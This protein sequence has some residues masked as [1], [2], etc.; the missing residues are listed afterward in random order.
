M[1]GGEILLDNLTITILAENSVPHKSRL[2]GQHGVSFWLEARSGTDIRRILVDV[3]QHPDALLF[4]ARELDID[5]GKTDA[6]VLTH[7]HHDH[8]EGLARILK[9]ISKS[10]LPV[11]VHPDLFRPNFLTKPFFQHLGI[12]QGDEPK[13]IHAAG[14]KLIPVRGPLQLMPGLATTGEI[15]RITDFEETPTARCTIDDDGQIVPDMMKDEL[16][17]TARIKDKGTVIVTGCSHAGIINI[18][19]HAVK[20]GDKVLGIVGGLHLVDASKERIEKTVSAM[21]KFVPMLVASG[22]CTGSR[23]QAVLHERFGERFSAMGPGT[24]FRF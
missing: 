1:K 21:E 6:I 9:A 5:L 24:V 10:D 12:R 23:A 13:D 17:L 11:V 22:H 20:E 15:P 2:L 18:L 4:N 14:G 16:A 19:K 7:C 8:T 3:G